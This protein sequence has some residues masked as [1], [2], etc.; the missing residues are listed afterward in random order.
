MVAVSSTGAAQDTVINFSGTWTGN[1]TIQG[2]F[3]EVRN[4][5]AS[6]AANPKTFPGTTAA[7]PT[8]FSTLDF[9]A[10]PGSLVT[11]TETA[12]NALASFF[13]IY[14]KS[15]DPTDLALNYL[16]DAGSS[17][18]N[19]TFSVR[20]PDDGFLVLVANSELG[21]RPLIGATY[22][23]KVTF[24]PGAA[25]PVPEPLTLSVFGAGVVGAGALRQRK[26]SKAAA[27]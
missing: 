21:T 25:S 22:S 17:G 5:V 2:K 9:T 11:I 4:G 20:A 8:Y 14:D 1:E 23:A 6:V 19:L 26:K 10:A 16:G 12:Q 7:D 18:Q 27:V 24:T 3:R 15:F 13:S